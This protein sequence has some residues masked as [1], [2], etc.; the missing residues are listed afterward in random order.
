MRSVKALR[1]LGIR[2]GE[3]RTG[4]QRGGPSLSNYLGRGACLGSLHLG[5]LLEGFLVSGIGG[6][7]AAKRGSGSEVTPQA[8]P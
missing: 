7:G 8:A 6:L 1:L 3:A 5:L 4:Q 2:L